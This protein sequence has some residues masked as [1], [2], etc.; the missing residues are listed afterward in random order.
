MF[1]GTAVGCITGATPTSTRKLFTQEVES[2][3]ARQ[4]EMLRCQLSDLEGRSEANMA[5]E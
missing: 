3:V 1:K 4:R 5:M 2:L